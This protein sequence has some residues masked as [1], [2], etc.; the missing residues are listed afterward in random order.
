MSKVFLDTNI[1]AYACDQD[2]P[3]KR[4]V[5]REAM[6]QGA[7]GIPPC[8]STQVVQ[9]FY[10]TATRKLN[11]APL[12]AK[13]VIFSFRH[14]ELVTVDVTDINRAVD[15]NILWQVSFWDALIIV[16]AQKARCEIL[17]TEDLN[18]GQLFDSVRVCNPFRGVA[19]VSPTGGNGA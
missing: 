9:E 6:A 8:I 1:L 11:I 18:D 5:A 17:Y 4:D 12:R 19:H 10:V 14:M 3:D 7:P 13:D 15:G 2:Q 16:A